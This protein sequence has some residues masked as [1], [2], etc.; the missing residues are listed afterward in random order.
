METSFTLSNYKSLGTRKSAVL[1]MWTSFRLQCI[2]LIW[3][4]L[5]LPE[6]HRIVANWTVLS[7][8][9]WTAA[10]TSPPN[11]GRRFRLSIILSS[12]YRH[13]EISPEQLFR[14]QFQHWNGIYCSTKKAYGAQTNPITITHAHVMVQVTQVHL[15]RRNDNV[16]AQ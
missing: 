2:S 14:C 16:Y 4:D 7:T 11:L 9:Y 12:S 6:I 5:L 10:S 1:H 8:R 15:C 3:W 13:E